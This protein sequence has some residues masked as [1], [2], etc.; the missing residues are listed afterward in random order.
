[1][2]EPLRVEDCENLM[3]AMNRVR[4]MSEDDCIVMA[5]YLLDQGGLNLVKQGRVRE[6]LGLPA[7]H[8]R[9]RSNETR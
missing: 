2:P 6:C 7:V 8:P 9:R 5:L 3:D 1:M 4:P